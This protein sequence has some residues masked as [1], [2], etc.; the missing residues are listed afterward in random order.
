MNQR[1]ALSLGIAVFLASLQLAAAEAPAPAAVSPGAPQEQVLRAPEPGRFKQLFQPFRTTLAALSPDGRYL[2][3]TLREGEVLSV[4]ILD[5][6]HPEKARAQVRAIDDNSATPMLAASQAEKTPGRINWM[7]WVTPN[8]LV[9]ET[10][11]IFARS[12]GPDTE[13]QS[14]RGAV[15]GFDADGGNARLLA[16]PDDLPE[17][18]TSGGSPYE[19]NVSRRNS[20][21]FDSHLVRPDQPSSQ[22][23]DPTTVPPTTDSSLASLAPD[24][25]GVPP[26]SNYGASQPRTLRIFDLD[27][28]HPGSV[29]LV[30]TGAPHDAGSHSVGLFSLNSLTGKLTNL[31]DDLLLNTRTALLDRQG[32]IR[33]TLPN[34]Q[35]AD[36]PFRYQY[37]GPKGKDRPRL[38]DDTT[39]LTGFDVSPDNYF[40]ARSIPLGF[41]EN[42][43]V[44]YYASNVGRDT[45]GIYSF[46]FATMRRGSLAMEN[47]VYDL[48]GPPDASFPDQSALVFDRYQHEMIGV[49]Y[50]NALRTTAWSRPEWKGLQTEFEKMFPG[51]SVEISD[52]DVTGNRFLLST[53]GPTDPGAFFV[54][55]RDKAKLM[56]FVRRAPWVDANHTHLTLPF[57]YALNDGARVSGLVTVPQQPRMKPIPMVVLCP[58]LPWQRVQS[59]FQTEV[60]ALADMGYVVVQLNGRGA[61]GLGLKQRQSL[62]AGYD[63]VQVEDLTTTIGNLEKIFNVNTKRV[64][65]MGRGHGGFIAL[66]ALQTYPDKF[67]CAIALDAP[68]NLGDWLAGQKWA[69]DDV[70]PQLTRAWLGDA[71][72]LKAAP[73]TSHPEAVT[74]PVLM[75]SYPGLDGERRSSAY[76]AARSFASS[77]RSR[78]TTVEFGDLTTDYVHGLPAARAAVFDRIEDFLNTH[79]YEFKVKVG[80]AKEKTD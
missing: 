34:S 73:L 51:R 18:S 11:R 74:K 36:F 77:V 10:N 41:A 25:S 20:A 64:A 12:A 49:R 3:Y 46:D 45:Y 70:Q 8:R 57:S 32:H 27:P 79:V 15:L 61:W 62:A 31:T 14:W 65:L 38:L 28:Q 50:D 5:I 16:G 17:F 43:S 63:L 72:R 22:A 69:D 55:D 40:G 24:D 1:S 47:S 7:K 78:G 2:A 35:L 67:R 75:L 9:I 71:A 29:T 59:D 53:E 33:L 39:G 52:W 66:R 23:P 48:I 6:D 58:D 19:F 13:W 80:E 68:V 76:A 42:S 30:A 21:T 4:V 60:Q 56:E 54:Y 44:L 37:F 26:T